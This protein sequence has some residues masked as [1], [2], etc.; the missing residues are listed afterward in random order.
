[1]P[2]INALAEYRALASRKDR[3]AYAAPKGSI[4]APAVAKL[5]RLADTLS[6]YRKSPSHWRLA[7]A[8]S[9]AGRT[10]SART[11][12]QINQRPFDVPI[13]AIDEDRV[14]T[15]AHAEYPRYQNWLCPTTSYAADN[16]IS[17][18]VEDF[19]YKGRHK[20]RIGHNYTPTLRCIVR[21]S[22]D[23][24]VLGAIIGADQITLLA[25]RGTTWVADT[26][27]ACLVR[28]RDGAD[29]HPTTDDLRAGVK[30]IYAKLVTLADQRKLTATNAKR[31]A[32]ALKRASKYG[33]YVCLA[34]S[35]TAGN[36]R[37][38]TESYARRNGLDLRK[39]YPAAVLPAPTS[40][41]ESRRIAL[42]VIAAQRRQAAD[43]AR[44]YS[45]VSL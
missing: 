5:Q 45:V 44:G 43:M 3:A 34:D 18:D 25:P 32:A 41:E 16:P 6:S 23:G 30:A 40:G 33:V 35:L 26:I 36:C 42:A 14:R 27:G 12:R 39:H 15:W 7:S 38:G 28:N 21:I 4:G 31:D 2:R 9:Q 13:G 20:G 17:V 29:F 24:S 10:L 22:A 19:A 8:V 37:A 1:M 11:E